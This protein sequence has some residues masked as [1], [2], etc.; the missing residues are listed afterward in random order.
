MLL[1]AFLLGPVF[2]SAEGK[3][4]GGDEFR[5]TAMKYDKKSEMYS[6]KGMPEVA[7]LYA[8]QAEIK[9]KAGKMGDEGRW[10]EIDWTEYHANEAKINGLVHKKNKYAKSHKKYK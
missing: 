8:R 6:D 9:R 2:V 5:A 4:K 7:S 1:T 10:D 3:S